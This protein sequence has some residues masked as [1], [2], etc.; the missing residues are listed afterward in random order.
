MNNQSQEDPGAAGKGR[1]LGFRSGGY[2]I[3]LAAIVSVAFLIRVLTP[4][5]NSDSL[6]DKRD[7]ASYGFDLSNSRVPLEEI[8]PAQMVKDG[9]SALVNPPMLSAEE[10]AAFKFGSHSEYLVS[11]DRVIGV[12]VAGE[13]R[14]YPLSVLNWHEIVNDTIGGEP[15]LVTYNPLCDSA[16]VYDRRVGG[17]VREF[18]VSG[19]LYNSNLLL[20]DRRPNLAEESLWSQLQARAIA[21]PAATSESKL[22]VIH[23]NLVRWADW[24]DR[25]PATKVVTPRADFIKRYKSNPFMNY[26]GID[27]LHFSVN[28]P[29]PEDG[30]SIKE[31]LI[32]V[33]VNGERRAY[34]LASV[35][36]RVDETSRW[37]TN[38]NGVPLVF[39]YRTDPPTAWVEAPADAGPV[40]V[41]YTFWFAWHAMYPEMP[42]DK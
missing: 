3:L 2:V 12:T 38:L 7:P 22:R 10:A 20:Y 5:F 4:L 15:V 37:T 39:H 9:L 11:S 16:V 42:L 31:R 28:P 25:H 19:L 17:E 30:P 35:A 36:D 26:F 13:A 8:I 14:A 41:I 32:V 23:T 1:L 29:P 24:R 40:E 27:K 6:G 18:G 34:T 33:G 21:G